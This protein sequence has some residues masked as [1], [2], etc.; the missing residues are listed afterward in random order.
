MKSIAIF[1][2]ANT[3]LMLVSMY[4]GHEVMTAAFFVASQA[5]CAAGFAVDAINKKG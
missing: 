5:F 3:L 4:A 1:A 2:I